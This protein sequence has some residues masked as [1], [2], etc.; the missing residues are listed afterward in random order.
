MSKTACNQLIFWESFESKNIIK[1]YDKLSWNIRFYLMNGW[2]YDSMYNILDF[3]MQIRWEKFHSK[4]KTLTKTNPK[5]KP[6]RDHQAHEPDLNS[7]NP[8]L[9]QLTS[10]ELLSLIIL[11]RKSTWLRRRRKWHWTD[12][13]RAAQAWERSRKIPPSEL[14][15]KQETSDCP[16]AVHS[17]KKWQNQG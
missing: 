14:R 6:Q 11:G 16:Q 8:I 1:L 12:K 10:K 2:F 7:T 17:D 4:F 15:A 9:S 5:Y 3:K 13:I